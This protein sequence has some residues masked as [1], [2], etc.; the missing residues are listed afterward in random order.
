[1]TFRFQARGHEKSRASNRTGRHESPRQARSQSTGED[2][3]VEWE[4]GIDL[5]RIERPGYV[6]TGGRMKR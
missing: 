6:R 5:L 1:M 3:Q 4:V 2:R